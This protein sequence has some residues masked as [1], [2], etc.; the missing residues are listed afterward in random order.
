M[1]TSTRKPSVLELAL[2]LSLKKLITEP[3]VADLYAR[4]CDAGRY[5][6]GRQP[7]RDVNRGEVSMLLS[8]GVF[9]TDSQRAAALEPVLKGML[10]RKSPWDLMGDSDPL[11]L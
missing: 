8:A 5:Y 3:E 1:T 6:S 7:G 4:M 2:A 9:L 10:A 11:V